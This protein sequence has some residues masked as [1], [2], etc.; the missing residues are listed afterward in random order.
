MVA[1]FGF[2]CCLCTC[3]AVSCETSYFD[4]LD[5]DAGDEFFNCEA[6]P[7]DGRPCSP[8]VQQAWVVESTAQ[9]Q[10]LAAAVDCSGGS[11]EVEWRGS[12]VVDT[13]INIGDG[14]VLSVTGGGFSPARIDGNYSTQLFRVIN[15]TLH[16][17]DIDIHRGS[18]IYGG[19]IA[20][21][22][23]RLTFDNANFTANDAGGHG[24]AVF[25]SDSSSM[26]CVGVRFEDNSA[27]GNGGAI[28]VEDRSRVSFDGD[29][30]FTV[31]RNNSSKFGDGGALHA[32]DSEAVWNHAE[33]YGNWAGLAGGALYLTGSEVFWN[34]DTLFM[35]NGAYGSGGGAVFMM[36]G[37][38]LEYTGETGFVDNYA[39]TDGGAIGSPAFDSANNPVDSTIGIGGGTTFSGN[40]CTANGGGL[41][42]LGACTVAITEKADV[43]F[44]EN[45]AGV[46]GGAVYV[47]GSGLGPTFPRVGFVNNE[48]QIGGAASITGSGNTK[49]AVDATPPNPTTFDS[50]Q[51]IENRAMAAGGAIES[52]AGHDAILNS[53]FQGNAARVGG[54]LRLAGSAIVRNCSFVENLSDNDEGAAVSNIGVI[55]RMEGNSF[56]R[57]IFS[58]P[59]DTFLNFT[60]VSTI[61]RLFFTPWCFLGSYRRLSR[62]GLAFQWHRSCSEGAR[63]VFNFFGVCRVKTDVPGLAFTM[64]GEP[65]RATLS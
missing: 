11:F 41:A 58:C 36:N 9:A 42:L 59:R 62:D 25:L 30:G 14:T 64:R 16:A 33:F 38:T 46:A 44:T 13:P 34:G 54:A 2:Q 12:V 4:C 29:G 53:L 35:W 55:S 56:H 27:R 63:G 32:T 28:L 60:L 47:S 23:S 61:S 31:F 10:A 5:P 26:S 8:E 1:S 15:A 57:N 18:G 20:A 19:A 51:F 45:R 40:N 65:G 43:S 37:S 24:G 39:L 50:C 48:A 6:P 49:D 17:T 52:A 3:S 21:A 7:P 22:G